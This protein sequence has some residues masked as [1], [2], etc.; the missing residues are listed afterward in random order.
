MSTNLRKQAAQ[1]SSLKE[2][3][4]NFKSHK[5]NLEKEFNQGTIKNKDILP[6]SNNINEKSPKAHYDQKTKIIK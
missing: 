5:P 2:M 6:K 4:I 1:I 3:L